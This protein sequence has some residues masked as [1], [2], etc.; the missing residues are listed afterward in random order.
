MTLEKNE[1]AKAVKK[2]ILESD[3]T[4]NVQGGHFKKEGKNIEIGFTKDNI[5]SS[6][7]FADSKIS[8]IFIVMYLSYLLRLRC[9][10]KC[11]KHFL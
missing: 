1:F 5:K 2:M 11:F 4:V 3:A 8:C 7:R 9:C 10:L 6:I